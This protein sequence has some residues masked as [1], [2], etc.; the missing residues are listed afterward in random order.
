MKARSTRS[1]LIIITYRKSADGEVE[2]P[3]EIATATTS[4]VTETTASSPSNRLRLRLEGSAHASDSMP[5]TGK[6]ASQQMYTDTEAR[7]TGSMQ[8]GL[9]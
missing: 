1:I 9:E 6:S 2:L 7:R 5:S 4:A 8:L 3:A